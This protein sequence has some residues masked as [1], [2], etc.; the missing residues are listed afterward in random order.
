MELQLTLALPLCVCDLNVKRLMKQTTALQFGSLPNET[1]VLISTANTGTGKVL[2]I[3][4]AA[5]P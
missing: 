5:F 1:T 4:N 2:E 3:K